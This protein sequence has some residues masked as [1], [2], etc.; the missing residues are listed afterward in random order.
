[1]ARSGHPKKETVFYGTCSSMYITYY[2]YVFICILGY[3]NRAASERRGACKGGNVLQ[4]SLPLIL[5]N[6]FLLNI[7]LRLKKKKKHV[8]G[9]A[10]KHDRHVAPRHVPNLILLIFNYLLIFN[11]NFNVANF[12]F[13]QVHRSLINEAIITR[14]KSIK[15]RSC[16]VIRRRRTRCVTSNS[17]VGPI[18]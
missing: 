12:K 14:K 17:I 3:N 2:Y 10:C 1:M 7:K 5:V 16:G 9:G 8:T 11:I 13:M 18:R 15:C 4:F 6:F